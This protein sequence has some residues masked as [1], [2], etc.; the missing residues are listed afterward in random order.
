[1]QGDRISS[2]HALHADHNARRNVVKFVPRA[3]S[4]TGAF[5]AFGAQASA[6]AR[7]ELEFDGTAHVFVPQMVGARTGFTRFLTVDAVSMEGV[8]GPARL[9]VELS[10]PPGA[11]MGD[12]P[13][14]ARISFRPEGW[15][16]YWVSPPDFPDGAVTIKH[17]D[18]SGP[19]P[20]IAGYF[21]VPLCFTQSPIHASDLTRC[22]MASGMFDTALV[23]D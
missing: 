14:D 7:L 13:Y 11:G 16:D 10:F 4:V 15:R 23:P 12:A 21:T 8:D 20:R 22:Q 3:L 17:L 5:L 18:L 9:V 19:A 6:E 1:M 2:G